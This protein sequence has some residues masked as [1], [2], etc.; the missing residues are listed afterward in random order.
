MKIAPQAINFRKVKVGKSSGLRAVAIVNSRTNKGAAAITTVALESQI[1]G[2]PATG[3]M[4][5]AAKS[6]C[7]EGSTIALGKGCK[8]FLSFAPVKSGGAQD[9]LVLDGNFDNSGQLV[10]LVGDGK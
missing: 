4:I 10:S 7:H 6:T 9:A 3:F 8:V 1:G 2:T 5:D